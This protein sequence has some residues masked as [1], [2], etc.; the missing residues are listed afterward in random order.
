MV[1]PH[2]TRPAITTIGGAI[3]GMASIVILGYITQNPVLQKFPGN[4]T[5]AFTTA[6]CFFLTGLG[7]LVIARTPNGSG[8]HT[9][10]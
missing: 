10:G 3:T 4:V 1:P 2:W 6:C 7:F 8:Y 5:M 9:K